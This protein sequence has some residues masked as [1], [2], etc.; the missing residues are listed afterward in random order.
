MIKL[1]IHSQAQLKPEN[2]YGFFGKRKFVALDLYDGYQGT[3]EEV[4]KFQEYAIGRLAVSNGSF[5]KTHT[6]RFNDFDAQAFRSIQEFFSPD[7]TL[8][9]HD[10]AVSDGR[11]SVPFFEALSGVYADNLEFLAS[12]YAAEFCVVRQEGRHRRIILDA[13]GNLIQFTCPPFVFNVVC[14]EN[15]FVYPVNFI[16]RKICQKVFAEKL[17]KEFKQNPENFVSEK[18]LLL[19]PECKNL[20]KDKRFTFKSLD[21]LSGPIGTH[22]VIRAMNILNTSYFEP[23]ILVRAVKNIFDSLEEG[24]LLITGSN[25]ESGSLVN[26]GVYRKQ[27]GTFKT[28]FESGSGS[29]VKNILMQLVGAP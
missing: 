1:G 17:Q 11:T 21:I 7:S 24:G 20:L 16:L 28:L 25:V 13:Q 8:N 12:D 6:A 9:I 26:G 23:E 18:L 10:M 5:K 2:L 4:A 29:P 27:N 15:A 22:H 3:P 14:P 19:C